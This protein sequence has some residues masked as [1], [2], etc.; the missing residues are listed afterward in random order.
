MHPLGGRAAGALA[1][2]LVFGLASIAIAQPTTRG[3][4]GVAAGWMPRNDYGAAASTIFVPEIVG[5]G[6]VGLGHRLYLRPGVRVAY[7]GFSQPQMPQSVRFSERDLATSVEAGILFNAAVVPSF[8]IGTTLVHRRTR[9]IAS[10]SVTAADDRIGGRELLPGVYTQ[11]G[12]GIPMWRG[13]FIMEPFVRWHRLAGDHR[14]STRAGVEF[15][16]KLF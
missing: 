6:Y 11:L 2:A 8:S 10:G 12:I 9:F 3:A 15:T 1:F 14:A 7:S 4:V 13:G 16:A 5:Y